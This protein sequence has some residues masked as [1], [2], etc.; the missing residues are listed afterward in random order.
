MLTTSTNLFTTNQYYHVFN[1]SID[2]YRIFSSKSEMTRFVHSLSFF[3]DSR[4]ARS[5]SK[6]LKNFLHEI[7]SNPIVAS[8]LPQSDLKVLCYC[9]MPTHYHLLIETSRSANISHFISLIENSHSRYLNVKRERKG[10]LWQSKYKKVRITTREQ[11]L[12]VSRYIHLNPSTS[13]L[14]DDPVRWKHSSYSLYLSDKAL[15]RLPLPEGAFLTSDNYKI[16]VNDQVDYQ[17]KLHI[18]KKHMA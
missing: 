13:N 3:N 18:M 10:P 4:R 9:V 7:P 5:F 1:K 16:F 17:K 15:R 8:F 14:I 2:G 6:Q 12:H 11:F